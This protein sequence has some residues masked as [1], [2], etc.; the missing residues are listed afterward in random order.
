MKRKILII[1]VGLLV[2]GIETAA[3][4]YLLPGNI[5]GAA[6]IFA[7]LGY[8]IGGAFFLA[9]S[10]RARSG[11]LADQSDR[12]LAALVPAA[13]L[14]LFAAPAEYMFLPPVL[15]R[16]AIMQW[17]GLGIILLGLALRLWVRSAL[18]NAYQGNLQVTER[19]ALVTG[20]PYRFVRHPGYLGFLLEGL[21]LAAGFSS[22]SG[23]VGVVF[24]GAALA[25][26][27]VVEEDMLRQAFGEEY[28]R[29]AAHTARLVPGIW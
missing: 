8:C 12:T 4:I 19:Q 3:G 26:R 28:T 6:L 17:A 22:L 2:G 20:G 29:Y 27:I 13:V 5:M 11:A 16:D 14:V 21:G 15:P 7:G 25:Y 24:L 10:G 9:L 1:V 23:M 18:K